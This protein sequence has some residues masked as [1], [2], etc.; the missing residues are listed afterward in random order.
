MKK[1]DFIFSNNESNKL[2]NKKLKYIIEPSDS[3]LQ[4]SPLNLNSKN[5]SFLNSFKSL[6]SINFNLAK[7]NNS[8]KNLKI[9]KNDLS[10][11]S[12]LFINK[13]TL[14][15]NILKEKIEKDNVYLNDNNLELMYFKNSDDENEEEE[16]D[17]EI[18]KILKHNNEI[19]N[20]LIKKNKIEKENEFY[21]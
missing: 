5:N 14:S 10:S 21:V 6:E 19:E 4:M 20:E 15:Q 12:G 2:I 17:L 1:V 13:F 3:N 9:K 8:M 16:K 18:L 7:R 11:K